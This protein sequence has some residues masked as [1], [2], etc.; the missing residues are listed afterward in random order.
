[1]KIQN[2]VILII[3]L[4]LYSCANVVPL[5]GGLK[6]STKPEIRKIS[7]TETNF[8]S[9]KISID[10]NEYIELNNPVKNISI[11]PF[12]STI[13]TSA[14]KKN[15]TIEIDSNLKE[16]TTY[17][18]KIDGGIKDANE[19]NLYSFN[20]SF[21]TGN[22]LDSA[23]VKF[24]INQLQ[25][26]TDYKVGLYSSP[27]DS[28]SKIKFDYISSFNNNMAEISGLKLDKVYYY[29]IYKD[30]NFDNI[31]D[32]YV[33]VYFDTTQ[34]NINKTISLAL[35]VDENIKEIEYKNAKKYIKNN[36][37]PFNRTFN[38]K[39]IIYYNNDSILILQS[40]LYD[41]M[42]YINIKKEIKMLLESKIT[43]LKDKTN[44]RIHFDKRGIKDINIISHLFKENN[45]YI[46]INNKQKIDSVLIAIRK[47][48]FWIKI[49]KY[50]EQN[51]LSHL[52]LKNNKIN[53]SYKVIISKNNA[54]IF[55]KIIINNTYDFYLTPGEYTIEIYEGNI[56]T[57]ITVNPYQYYKPKPSKVNKK[58]L[59]KANWDEEILL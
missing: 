10:F 35:W 29:F 48:T 58:I 14:N 24:T 13:T 54:I 17:V 56:D 40:S 34:T 50:D 5:E 4:S 18:L 31:P 3:L 47:D 37:I 52:L 19:G 2:Y 28:F 15:I 53:E 39:D 57:K 26:L 27:Y 6:D 46:E 9:K 33:P 59:L 38:E 36:L 23:Y 55:N 49:N 20:K 11:Q 25:I 22:T 43:A 12:H 30:I 44:Y 7:L 8:K 45:E 16:N 42:P 32:K 41:S 21:A 1:M 51:K